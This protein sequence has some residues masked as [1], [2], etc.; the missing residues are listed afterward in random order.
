MREIDRKCAEIL[1]W[2]DIRFYHSQILDADEMIGTSPDGT[3]DRIVP[4]FFSNIMPTIKYLIP[5]FKESDYN[6]MITFSHGIWKVTVIADNGWHSASD[7]NLSA[8]IS[9]VFIKTYGDS[10]CSL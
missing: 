10:K 6:I 1:G 8:A 2:K 9:L 7:E 4:F 3:K 5:R